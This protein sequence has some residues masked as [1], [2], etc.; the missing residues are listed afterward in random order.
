[1]FKSMLR[2]LFTSASSLVLITFTDHAGIPAKTRA[3]D[4]AP[5]LTM[6]VGK[7]L[8]TYGPVYAQDA[9][10][11]DAPLEMRT[12]LEGP[13]AYAGRYDAITA[14][15]TSIRPV[16]SALLIGKLLPAYG[17]IYAQDAASCDAPLEIRTAL[18][19]PVAYAGRY[20]AITAPDTSI[21]TAIRPVASAI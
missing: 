12:V 1:M 21:V 6:L 19:G 7:L 3:D 9:A 20:D 17:P 5:V 15:D 18:E 4:Q 2:L 13:V 11:C 8:P 16:T 10:S 14:P